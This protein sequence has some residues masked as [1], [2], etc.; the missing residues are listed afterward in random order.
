MGGS[1]S[2]DGSESGG[3][4]AKPEVVAGGHIDLVGLIYKPGSEC[5]NESDQHTFVNCL[6]NNGDY[7]E[8]D[9][10]EQLILNLAFSQPVKLHS[11]KVKGP[12]DNGPKIM[13]LFLNQTRTLDFDQ[14][15][16]MEAV[17]L[18]ELSPKDLAD[19]KP[20]LLKYVKF[21]NVNNLIVSLFFIHLIQQ[22]F[23]NS[24]LQF[25]FRYL[26]RIIN[27]GVRRLELITSR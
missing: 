19:A 20:I 2:N 5:L 11:I 14:A 10:D 27:L 17:Q 16:A 13:K 15:D 6:T 1:L 4:G 21:Q 8:S 3:G 24:L 12:V 26:S 9:C 23:S 22:A 25:N 7:L 18:I